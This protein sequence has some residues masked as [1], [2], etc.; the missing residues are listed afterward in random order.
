MTGASFGIGEA[1]AIALAKQE[2]NLILVARSTDKLDA[3][4]EEYRSQY[5]I[6]VHVFAQ[7]LLLP[8]AVSQV[9]AQLDAQS[10]SVDLLIN[11]AGFGDYGEFAVSNR[12]KQLD[13]IQ[14]NIKVLVELTHRLLPP[15]VARKSGGIINISSIAGFQPMPYLSIYAATKAFVLSFSEALWAENKDQ[16]VNVMVV[17]PGPTDTRFMEVANFPTDIGGN[18]SNLATADEVVAK[19]LQGFK[20]QKPNVVTGGWINNVI[21]NSSRFVPRPFLVNGLKKIFQPSDKQSL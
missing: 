19:A 9:M 12:Q 20:R 10:I 5:G 14:L 2:Y 18:A 15:M 1:F 13:M 11:N 8:N 3:M 21:V 4:A 7:D 17:C 6:S 16:G